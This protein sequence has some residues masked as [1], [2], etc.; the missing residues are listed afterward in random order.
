MKPTTLKRWIYLA[1]LVYATFS[2]SSAFAQALGLAAVGPTDPNNGYPAWYQ[3][4]KGLQLAPCLVFPNDATAPVP[5]PCGLAGILP[6]D[7]APVVF[8]DN[9]PDEFFYSFADNT[10]VGVGAGGT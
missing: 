3:D 5:D 9:F 8:P 2:A 1:V 7:N 10:I 4:T 6:N